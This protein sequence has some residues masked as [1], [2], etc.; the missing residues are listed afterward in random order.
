MADFS[1]LTNWAAGNSAGFNISLTKLSW[2]DDWLPGFFDYRAKLKIGSRTY[3]GRGIDAKEDIACDKALAEALER[4][5]V[6]D[7]ASPWAT[8]AYPEEAGAAERAYRELVCID[9]VLCH[10]FCRIP[11]KSLKMESLAGSVSAD[12]LSRGLR[13]NGFHLELCELRPV[14]DAVVV[15]AFIWSERARKVKGMVSGFG[16]EKKAE[17]AAVHAVIECLRTAVPV[18]CGELIPEP[19]E[20]RCV[21]GNPRWHFWMAQKQEAKDFLINNLLTSRC[22][23]LPVGDAE[24]ISLEDA[25]LN[26]VRSLESTIPD[27]PVHIMQASSPKLLRPQFGEILMDERFL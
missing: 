20:L 27:M 7:M 18:F 16:C 13:K 1:Q 26:K 15:A 14:S 24:K 22:G 11:F 5:A 4:A 10:H 17:D 8:A 2:I 25:V 3:A 19:W 9:R 23:F 12:V 6:A 21:R